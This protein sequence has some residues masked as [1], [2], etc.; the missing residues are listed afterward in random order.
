MT[1]AEHLASTGGRAA[2]EV[3]VVV[4]GLGPGGR[5]LASALASEGLDVVGVEEHLVGGECPF[6]GCTPSKMMVRAAEA[7]AE[8]RRVTELAG[9]ATVVP[10]WAQ[11]AERIS[12]EATSG[13]NDDDEVSALKAAGVT[14]V[15]GHGRLAGPRTVAVDGSTYVARRGVVLATGTAPGAPPIDGLAKTPYWT[16]R[17]VV[18]VTELPSSLAV[19]G[20]GAIGAE[21]CQVFGRFGVSVTLLEA[22]PRILSEAEPEASGL[23]AE[24]I[25]EEGVEV[26]TGAAIDRVDHDGKAFVLAVGDRTITSD[27]LLVAAGRDSNL[28]DIG[29]PSV[30][31]DDDLSVLE[32]DDRMR[33]ADGL[34]AL[35]DITGKGAYTSVAHYQSHIAAAAILGREDG[36]VADYRAVPH[37]TFTDP[38]IGAVGL[39]EDAARAT[40]VRVQVGFADM[41][42]SPRGWIH[43]TG[44]RGFV[45]VVEDADAQVLLGATVA[46]PMAGELLAHLTLAVHARIP[47]A[48]LASMIYA[49]PTFSETVD[50]AL[51]SLA[52]R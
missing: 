32:T 27:R 46:G 6:Y 19:I 48:S 42:S 12:S 18:K 23:V 8:A 44:N 11:V 38:E 52:D 1:A 51:K 43:K 20:G 24:T 4:L 28:S 15:R 47:V 49:F 31:L 5:S 3:D 36:P 30:G 45:K 29:L 37:V 21:L 7:L 35:G 17:D 25:A 10:R 13:W 26:I 33:V 34:W 40:G 50:E 22:E 41:A 9:T 14:F 39:T 16:N 2:T